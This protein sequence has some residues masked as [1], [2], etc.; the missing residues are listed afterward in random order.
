MTLNP[1]PLRIGQPK[2]VLAHDR[3]SAKN[4]SGAYRSGLPCLSSQIMSFDPS[5]F[6]KRALG[7][8]VGLVCF[9][10]A[11]AFL[12]AQSER[13]FWLRLRAF[14]AGEGWMANTFLALIT[15]ALLALFCSYNR[16]IWYDEFVNYAFAGFDGVLDAVQAF[17]KTSGGINLNQ[18]GVYTLLDYWLLKAFGASAF[19]LRFPSL[20]GGLFMFVGAITFCRTRA[21]NLFWQ[22]SLLLLLATQASVIE[23][24]GEARP[25]MPFAGTIIGLLGYYS[26]PLERR[27]WRMRLFAWTCTVFGAA[28]HPYFAAYYAMVLFVTYLDGLQLRLRRISVESFLAH[29]EIP[30]LAVAAALYVSIGLLTWMLRRQ[31]ISLDSFAFSKPDDLVSQFFAMHFQFLFWGRPR[32]RVKLAFFVLL[33]IGAVLLGQQ[34]RRRI[35]GPVLLLCSAMMLTM[36]IS[37]MSYHN[38]Y[39]IL[40]RQWIAS[41]AISCC[42]VIWLLGTIENSLSERWP[43]LAWTVGLL[44]TIYAVDHVRPAIESQ[45]NKIAGWVE[46]QNEAARQHPTFKPGMRGADWVP[47]ANENIRLGGPVWPIFRRFYARPQ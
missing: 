47:F 19:W 2:Q 13:L 9:G 3:D 7:R 26:A 23:Y 28:I 11:R 46:E 16:P 27:S 36:V 39:W 24:L 5:T 10:K 31:E 32:M 29:A 22:V 38:H 45:L 20:V 43:K 33:L 14:A 4:E 25:Y 44:V 42:A 6:I 21:L 1:L 15:A 41:I 17:N 40:S 35:L 12:D 8:E 37:W 34:V 18:T 30:M